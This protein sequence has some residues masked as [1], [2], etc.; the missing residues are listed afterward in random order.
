MY[1]IP[2][3]YVTKR[4][5]DKSDRIRLNVHYFDHAVCE[6]EGN[7]A[8]PLG[9][10][11]RYLRCHKERARPKVVE[12]RPGRTFDP[13]SRTCEDELDARDCKGRQENDVKNQGV[14]ILGK[15]LGKIH[16]T[17]FRITPFLF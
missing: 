13:F 3:A 5:G 8:H 2:F 1:R 16:A 4:T 17:Q 9:D 10:C 6:E 11:H 7:F 15:N 12:C 14:G